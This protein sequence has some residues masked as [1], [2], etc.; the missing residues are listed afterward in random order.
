[1]Q[2]FTNK[3][4]INQIDVFY[5]LKVDFVMKIIDNNDIVCKDQNKYNSLR[6][7]NAVNKFLTSRDEISEC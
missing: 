6:K 1:M 7:L 2:S 3:I 4:E 5:M